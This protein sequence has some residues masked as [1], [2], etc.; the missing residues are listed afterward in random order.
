LTGSIDK[1]FCAGADLNSGAAFS[2][3]YAQQ[4]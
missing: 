3:D 2:F 1:A 4:F